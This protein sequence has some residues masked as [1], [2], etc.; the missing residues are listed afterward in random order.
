MELGQIILGF[1][2]ACLGAIC[3]WSLLRSGKHPS[4]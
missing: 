2:G 3:V 4:A 1:A